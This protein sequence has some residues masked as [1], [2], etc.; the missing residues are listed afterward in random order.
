[1]H[2]TRIIAILACITAL[3]ALTVDVYLPS[4]PG[5]V[6]DLGTTESLVQQTVTS[7][8]LGLTLAQ[9]LVGPLSDSCGRRP[10][11]L[12]GLCVY[13]SG[14]ILCALAPDVGMLILGRSVQGLGAAATVAPARAMIRDIWHGDAAA[15]ALSLVMMLV[16]CVPLL[17]PLA[18]A[19]IFIAAGWRVVFW[20]LTGLAMV[21]AGMV[22]TG[23]PETMSKSAAL[24]V[25]ASSLRGL[26]HMLMHRKAWCY[27]MWSGCAYG[28]LFAYIAGVPFLYLSSLGLGPVRFGFLVAV[29]A[30]GVLM[31]NG[32]NAK[33][34]R[35]HGHVRMAGCG[36]C[37]SLLGSALLLLLV[38]TDSM[39]VTRA[40]VALFA[41]VAPVA[42]TVANGTVGLLDLFP[43]HAGAAA[44]LGGVT[45][46][47]MATMA[48]GLVGMLHDSGA[49]A[50]AIVMTLMA[51]G[52]LL[53][54]WSM[55]RVMA[56]ELEMPAHD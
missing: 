28:V 10:V 32:L 26:G 52:G 5:I 39:S 42:F 44:G 15:R 56:G 27:L 3:G 48:G 38:L 40:V 36:L 37:C 24:H 14:S 31:M 17:A 55:G 33:W 43:Q 19:G 35:T 9:L 13:L 54:W 49:W 1:M 20:V 23:L 30:L 2:E 7:Y 12:G 46:F 29:N 8:L 11:I 21:F 45:Q 22:V 41:A 53:A 47:G 18:G 4:L 51:A 25:R 16:A 6:V 34:V 50:M